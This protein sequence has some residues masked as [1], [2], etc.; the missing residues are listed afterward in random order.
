[1]L[2]GALILFV[3]A[4]YWPMWAALWEYW[5]QPYVGGQGVLVA[6]LSAW[7]IFRKRAELDATP[8]AP[9]AWA[10][11]FLF[12]CGAATLLFAHAGIP[13]LYFILLPAL[14]LITVL[15]ALGPPAARV[16]LVPVAFLYF[17]IPVW[18]ILSAPLQNLTL[19][20]TRVLAP[21]L[22]LP[23]TVHGT[24][25]TFPNGAT[26]EVTPLCSG[27]GFLVQGLATATILGELEQAPLG[28]RVAL[29]GSVAV[30]AILANWARVMILMEVGYTTGM[31]HVLVTQDHVL[32]G[33]VL[34]VLILL[35]FVFAATRIGRPEPA[36]SSSMP[37]P[38]APAEWKKCLAAML[39]LL[40]APLASHLAA[41]GT[42]DTVISAQWNW[43][44]ARGDWRGP[45]PVG[46]DDDLTPGHGKHAQSRA[47]YE[48][49]AGVG[50]Q[51]L[52]IE[53]LPT[54]GQTFVSEGSALLG[55]SLTAGPAQVVVAGAQSYNETVVT[56]PSGH[57]AV[58]WSGYNVDGRSI[59]QP[60]LSQLWLGVRSLVTK[61]R[62]MLFALRANCDLSSCAA[63]RDLLASF[64][65]I[66]GP[67][68]TSSNTV[69]AKDTA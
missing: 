28:R 53:F 23:A 69:G 21:L 41:A 9:A 40:A 43:P 12:A 55:A 44:A 25:V 63:A 68:L 18:S 52:A 26:F 31:R 59:A 57:R 42:P 27:L 48:S 50:V 35:A 3:V 64:V 16:L 56:D 10:L 62:S 11:P 47:V 13:T 61:P 49:T 1:L 7:L 20:A 33:E 34:F 17:G 30:V 8:T 22:G 4:A 5:L 2:V 67:E 60:R 66:M 32:F 24:F 36:L 38:A 19:D 45:L 15:A 51:A 54:E 14:V 46:A 65:R 37:H 58:I 29:L 39:A 6:A